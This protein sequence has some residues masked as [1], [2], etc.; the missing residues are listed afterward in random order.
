MIPERSSSQN[1]T[2]HQVSNAQINHQ[3]GE[4]FGEAALS[5]CYAQRNAVYHENEVDKGKNKDKEDRNF[6]FILFLLLLI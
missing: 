1:D 3:L 6:L 4:C 2:Q 5:P